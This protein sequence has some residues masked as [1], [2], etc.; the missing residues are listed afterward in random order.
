MTI[1]R[2]ILAILTVISLIPVFLSLGSSLSEPQV[3]ARL[4]LYQTNLVLQASELAVKAGADSPVGQALL[5]SDPYGNAS[6]QLQKARQ[7]AEKSRAQLLSQRETLSAPVAI[8]PEGADSQESPITVASAVQSQRLQKE[9]TEIQGFIQEITL[10]LGIVQARRGEIEAAL[11]TWEQIEP[12]PQTPLSTVRGA[13]F[14]SSLW[15]EPPVVL[16]DAEVELSSSLQ[17]WFRYQALQR[18]YQLENRDDDLAALQAEQAQAAETALSKLGL[19]GG[20]PFLTRALLGYGIA[21]FLLVQR[22]TAGEKAVLAISGNLAWET[23]WSGEI[24]WQVLIVGF[25]LISQ[26]LLPLLISLLGINLAGTSIRLQAFYVMATYLLVAVS[27]IAVLYFSIRGYR[28]LPRDWFRFRWLSPWLLWGLGGYAVAVP[29]VVVVSLLNQQI[30]Q[31]QGGSNPLLFL[32]LQANDRLALLIFFVTASIAA[33]I[34]E[35]IMFRGFLLPSLT[36][37]LPVWGAIV[38]SSLIFSLAHLSLAEVLPLAILGMV[39]AVVYTRSRNLLASI[40]LH[41]LWNSGTL[42]SL[43]VLGSG[44][45]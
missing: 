19:I 14:L 28:P 43:F 36:R 4:E 41:S 45:S 32:A 16:P 31:G 17:G 5:G 30:W 33:P 20:L 29:L 21:D 10:K 38:V 13:R 42:V 22:L 26:I 18:L 27:G 24:I 8:A 23:P 9:L 11:T 37:Y 1:K 6:E 7:L 44:V 39:L 34:F 35:E 3:Q 12:N 2:I 25:F 40:L 15:R